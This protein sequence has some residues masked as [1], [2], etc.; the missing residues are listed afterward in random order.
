[1]WCGREEDLRPASVV[2]VLN[3]QMAV[4]VYRK[5]LVKQV[6]E[7]KMKVKMEVVTSVFGI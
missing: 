6:Q 4:P 7:S 2:Q 1:M 5:T 3:F